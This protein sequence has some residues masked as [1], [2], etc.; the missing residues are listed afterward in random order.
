MYQPEVLEQRLN[1]RDELGFEMRWCYWR[2]WWRLPSQDGGV[3][4]DDDDDDFPLREGSSPGGIA[5]PE[6]KS[7]RAKVSPRGGGA[8]SRK[9]STYFSRSKW[10]IYQKM[11]TRG[12]LGGAQP[13]R[14]RPGGL[15]PPGG[16][17]L[18]LICSNIHHIFHKHS[19]WSFRLFGVVQNR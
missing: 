15:C 14:A 2:C 16:P 7:A 11:G 8:S 12:G 6:G 3:I 17:P 13:T 10:L 4:G 1:T 19:T 18:V 5:P 9:S